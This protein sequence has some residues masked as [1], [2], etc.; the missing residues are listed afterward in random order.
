MTERLLLRPSEVADAL[1][2]SRS[3]A[4]DLINRGEIPSIKLAGG[5]VR[6]PV[7]AL[8]AKIAQQLGEQAGRS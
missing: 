7:E 3:K 5:S 6:V 8:K 2:V 1:G 4:Y